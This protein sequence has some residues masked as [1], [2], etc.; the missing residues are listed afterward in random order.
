MPRVDAPS[1]TIR[2]RAEWWRRTALACQAR[3][4]APQLDRELAGGAESHR[5]AFV[6]QRA[7]RITRPRSRRRLAA[8]LAG[9]LRTRDDPSPR[10]NAAVS[11]DRREVL[12]ARIVL[13]ALEQ[14]LPA[15]QPVRAPGMAMIHVDPGRRASLGSRGSWPRHPS[16]PRAGR[17][18]GTAVDSISICASS[19]VA[20]CRT[21]SR[22]F[23]GPRAPHAWKKYCTATRISPSTPRALAF[24]PRIGT[25]F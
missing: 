2:L 16:Q 14:R 10:L 6:Q 11:P 8:G 7:V 23:L 12:A 15:P 25:A 19:S 22:Y 13:V 3:Y 21:M 20:V 5:H 9:V 18:R 17:P 24:G 4:R 1:L